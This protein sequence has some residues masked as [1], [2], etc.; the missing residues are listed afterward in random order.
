M[1]IYY[2]CIT[3]SFILIIVGRALYGI[4]GE[5]LMVCQA[6]IAERW[7]TGKFLTLAIGLGNSVC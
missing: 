1:I 4:G 6:S 2:A 5:T 7:F 3:D